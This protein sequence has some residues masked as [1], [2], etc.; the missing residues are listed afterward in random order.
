MK[1]NFLLF[2][3]SF[4]ILFAA[5]AQYS[6]TRPLDVFDAID[7]D[8]NARIYFEQGETPSIK[9]Q[10]KKEHHVREFISEVKHGTLHLGFENDRENKRKIRLTIIHTGINRMDMDGFVNMI[11]Y[12]PLTSR[13]LDIKADGFIKG[14]LEV[15]VEDLQI[16]V[17]GFIQLTVYGKADRADLELD[18]FG[19]IDAQD[20]D[21]K[22]RRKSAD[23]FAR[24]KF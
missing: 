5:Q 13:D 10:G 22:K 23:G 14:D 2:A 19:N 21:V 6:E 8:G 1:R 17:D 24:I 7:F 12:D 3:F 11:S 4:V 15:D 9:I 20:L 16:D 18:G